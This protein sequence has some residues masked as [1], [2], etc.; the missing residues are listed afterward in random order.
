MGLRTG[1]AQLPCIVKVAFLA[2]LRQRQMGYEKE[3]KKVHP[4]QPSCGCWITGQF[5]DFKSVQVCLQQLMADVKWK[6][7]VGK[8]LTFQC[9]QPTRITIA[10]VWS[11]LGP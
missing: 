8:A 11:I 7:E 4:P 10:T 6:C 1:A 3:A 5:H 2:D 9:W